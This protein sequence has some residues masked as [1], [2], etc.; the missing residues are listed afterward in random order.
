M[1]IGS[2]IR[3]IRKQKGLT[4]KQL[5]KACKIAESTI[6]RYE[7]GDLNP[8]IETIKKI[9]DALEVSIADISGFSEYKQSIIEK[10]PFLSALQRNGH[11]LDSN[12][13]AQDCLH[14]N[15][16]ENLDITEDKQELLY[17]YNRLNENGKKEAQKRVLELTEI[18]RYVE[19]SVEYA[20]KTVANAVQDG[21]I[22]IVKKDEE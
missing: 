2:R 18:P 5:G 17:A 6:R 7:L 9:A 16:I 20:V 21:Q 15:L 10:S 22:K 14:A 11:N 8:K 13:L 3:E 19:E 1:S 12:V 4:Q